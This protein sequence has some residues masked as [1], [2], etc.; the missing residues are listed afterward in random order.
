MS[1]LAWI[2]VEQLDKLW[3]Q[4]VRKNYFC[5]AQVIPSVLAR[6]NSS[7]T[8]K[9]IV[10]AWKVVASNMSWII[11]DGHTTWFWVDP[12]VP[13]VAC[14]LDEVI[15]EVPRS[16][17]NY[18]VSFYALDVNW[19]WDRIRHTFPSS[20]CTKIA[21]IKP[22]LGGQHDFPSC[23]L[24]PRGYFSLKSAYQALRE[25][26]IRPILN[27]D[28]FMVVLNWH[29][30]PRIKAFM[31]K[32]C[33]GRLMTNEKRSKLHI[34]DNATCPRCGLQV[35]SM[36]HVL[37]DCLKIFVFWEGLVIQKFG[38]NLL[39]GAFILGFNG[40]LSAMQSDHFKLLGTLCLVLLSMPFGG[41]RSPLFFSKKPFLNMVRCSK[42]G[43]W[44]G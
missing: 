11:R 30:P 26:K 32:L 16:E 24:E 29:D 3:V 13:G 36:M 12:W 20:V 15:G 42:F 41:I 10:Q 38:P 44:H 22:P 37:R 25:P 27:D 4:N 8:W 18:L 7:Y 35:E 33:H 40:I 5:G 14:L 39:L 21:N 1:K 23:N 2:F 9:P 28:L 17:D 19:I 43:A 6:S 31:W 34:T